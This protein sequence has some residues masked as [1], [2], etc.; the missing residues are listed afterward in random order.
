MAV[1]QLAVWCII[2]P[3]LRTARDLGQ[4]LFVLEIDA[5][6]LNTYITKG[7]GRGFLWYP[8]AF[9][10]YIALQSI[11]PLRLLALLLVKRK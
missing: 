2:S 6:S 9:Y 11:N 4:I 8:V 3:L 1:L 5:L 10:Y 7:L